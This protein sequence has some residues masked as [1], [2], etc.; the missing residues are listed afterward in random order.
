MSLTEHEAITAAKTSPTARGQRVTLLRRLTGLSRR[1]IQKKY[2][3]PKTTLQNWEEAKGNGLTEKGARNLVS[4]LKP[5]GIICSYEWLMFGVGSSP[6]IIDRQSGEKSTPENMTDDEQS[7]LMASELRLFHQ[8]YPTAIDYVVVDDGMEPRFIPGEQVAGCRQHGQAI[9]ACVGLDCI[10]QVAAGDLL[11]RQIKQRGANG[12]Y[13]L[14]CINPVT[15]VEKPVLYDV[16][17][18][19]AA[20]VIWAR[21]KNK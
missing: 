12:H 15:T 20:P 4:V 9:E 21:R 8:H 5:D 17:L 16:E 2:G 13:T 11:L 6:Q 14:S 10:V 3:I 18:V 1:L 7:A 19:M